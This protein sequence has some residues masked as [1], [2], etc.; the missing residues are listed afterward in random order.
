MKK[1]CA[2]LWEEM[3]DISFQIIKT[4]RSFFSRLLLLENCL[5]VMLNAGEHTTTS[6]MLFPLEQSCI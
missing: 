3:F 4:A 6:F 1:D 5:W 2:N